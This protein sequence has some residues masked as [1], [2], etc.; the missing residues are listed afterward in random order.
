M[1]WNLTLAEEGPATPSVEPAPSGGFHALLLVE[2]EESG[3]GRIFAADSVTWRDPPFPLMAHDEV[4]PEH[5]GAVLIG[6]FTRIERQGNEIH[7]YGDWI[8][9]PDEDASCLIGLVE[10]GELRGI[11]ATTEIHEYELLIPEGDEDEMMPLFFS[12]DDDGYVPIPMPMDKLRVLEAKILSGT[13]EP[14]PA[15][16]RCFIEGITKAM[17]AAAAPTHSTGLLDQPWDA[18]SEEGKLPDPLDAA[19]AAAMYAWVPDGD[20]VVAGDC[21]HPHHLVGDDGMPG[22]A[23]LAALDSAMGSLAADDDDA[24]GIYDHLAGHYSDNSL[25]PPAFPESAAPEAVTAAP[26]P[27]APPRA[28]F[29]HDFPKGTPQTVTDAGRVF[30]YIGAWTDCHVSFPDR[31]VPPPRS[32][33]NYAHFLMGEI[34]CSDGSRVPVGHIARR[35]GHADL[36]LSPAA[37]KAF[38]DD[39]DSVIADVTCGEDDYGIWIAGALR[40]EASLAEVRTLMASPPSGDWRRIG[41]NH[42]LIMI[43]AVNTP[44]FPRPRVRIEDGLVASFV[45]PFSGVTVDYTA[46]VER[47]ARSIGRD[48]DTRIAELAARVHVRS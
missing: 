20:P 36:S 37:A 47:I 5:L 14:E 15:F 24:Q 19:T 2:D 6:N 3:D 40:P 38:Y 7:G 45:M 35:G 31:C 33:T 42:E 1:R 34:R 21:R 27:V 39:T 44:G 46:A 9:E 30:G 43:S 25:E 41:G 28:W 22:D 13:V 48:A 12:E 29:D 4:T 26:F 16:G 17:T 8:S 11:S 23:V 18:G 32:A 10:R